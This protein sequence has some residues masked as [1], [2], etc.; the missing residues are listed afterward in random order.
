MA[1]KAVRYLLYVL[2]VVATVLLAGAAV[3][4]WR[5][6]Y[7][8]PAEGGVWPFFALAMPGVLLL[9]LGVLVWWLYRKRWG[10]ALLPAAA[11][12]LN[13]GYI[14][15]MVQLPDLG[16]GKHDDY[17]CVATFNVC[18]F[19]FA[20]PPALTVDG[21]AELMRRERVDVL[22]MQEFGSSREMP[23]DSIA[24]AFSHRMPYFVWKGSQAL[25]S[26]FP[27][28]DYRYVQFPETSNDYLCADLRI[29][30]DTVR[31]FSVHLQTTGVARLRRRFRKDYHREA[32][33]EAVYTALE[34]NGR[35]RAQQVAEIRRQIDASPLPVIL[36]GDFN[37]TPSSYTYREIKGDMIDGFR[38]GGSGYGGTYRYLG[39]LLRID[40]IFYDD[41]FRGAR[42]RM[43]D[44]R[45]LSDHKPVVTELRF[46][47]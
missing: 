5:A 27:I 11:L 41:T 28:L 9:N 6:S 2:S 21:I 3:V 12:V 33:V 15:A 40:Y 34:E 35:I 8:S 37:D 10:V 13:M 36:M 44:E 18:G 16:D 31:L 23:A 38:E 43:P 22:A 39:G 24:A 30:E 32:P 26:R 46:N 14:S 19:H 4:S 29:G 17:F 1:R 20:E 47:Q 7:V 45:S 25:A 42:Y